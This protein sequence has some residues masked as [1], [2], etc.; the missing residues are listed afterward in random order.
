MKKSEL[1]FS[2]SFDSLL[3]F[4]KKAPIFS[5]LSEKDCIHLLN[6][7][8]E[9][10]LSQGDELFTEGSYGSFAYIIV[11]GE[12]EIYTKSGD[13]EVRLALRKTGEIIG[14][15]SLLDGAPRMASAR[16]NKE[17]QVLEIRG[18]QFENLLKTS[19]TAAHN[20]LHNIILRWR[21][22]ENILREREREI[23]E[24]SKLLKE[25]NSL[26]K[27]E[28]KKR[29]KTE[30]DIEALLNSQIQF[31]ILVNTNFEIVKF[32]HLASSNSRIIFGKGM[33]EGDKINK[34]TM[35]S[36]R[37]EFK[38]YFL[39]ALKGKIVSTELQITVRDLF[40]IWYEFNFSPVYNEYEKIQGIC[41][42][43]V[44]VTIRKKAEEKIKE[45]NIQL[46]KTL[47]ELK[48][49]Q[50]QILQ[51]EKLASLGTLV[52]GVAHEI[53][54][55][56]NF[57]SISTHNIETD[58]KK[59]E[60]FLIDLVDEEEEEM[61][62][63]FQRRFHNYNESI[64]DIK[65]GIRRVKT[66]VDDLKT[67]SHIDKAQQ[68]R[69]NL[70][71]NINSTLRIVKAQY[72]KFIEFVTDFKSDPEIECWPAQINQV[73]INTLINSCHA[74][75]KKQDESKQKF[76]GVIIIRTSTYQD[77][78]LIT[79]HD[80]GCG[81]TKEIQKKIFEPFFTTKEIGQGTGMGLSISYGI[82]QK[83]GGKIEVE[84]VENEGS[85]ITIHLPL[86]QN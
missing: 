74:I 37:K 36:N 29:K 6:L 15:M 3:Y 31:V 85:I 53:N 44:D 45:Q 9:L 18:D 13:G 77:S 22:T 26:L 68:K 56:V 33:K 42:T 75:K 79:I 8:S 41:I 61:I 23:L 59:F 10:S 48:N 27:I 49:A 65:E 58:L 40:Q 11:S 60:D 2:D 43:G 57:I 24:Q 86:K 20:I 54:N 25:K 17:S 7:A 38:K 76:H 67:F 21:D 1:F 73:L 81:M 69:V 84:S 32:N 51:S 12:I 82:I 72:N 55:P 80:N 39:K 83:H 78:F 66:I 34:Y 19:P 50:A 35:P 63:I 52:A 46:T 16:A 62:N 14:E 71:D 4:L 47:Q 30:A 28:I 5:E 64:E 70:V